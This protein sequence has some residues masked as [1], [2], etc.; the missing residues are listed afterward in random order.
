[1]ENQHPAT[2]PVHT[3]HTSSCPVAPS[4]SFS[5]FVHAYHKTFKNGQCCQAASPPCRT[6][7]LTPTR[8]RP[9]KKRTTPSS[10]SKKHR[11]LIFFLVF[12]AEEP[13][14]RS[15]RC[16]VRLVRPRLLGASWR[17]ID[18]RIATRSRCVIA[19]EDIVGDRSV[20]VDGGGGSSM[21]CMDLEAW[22]P[23]RRIDE[24]I[25]AIGQTLCSFFLDG[26]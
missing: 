7:R 1:M 11:R 5:L 3:A 2:A 9:K 18:V 25:Q 13:P 14:S 24:W 12:R 23:V 20:P 6:H 19:W 16:A 4:F 26:W 21:R 8:S 10:N 15:E 22:S 17:N